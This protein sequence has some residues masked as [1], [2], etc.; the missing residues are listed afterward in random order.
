VSIFSKKNAMIG[1]VV[2]EAAKLAAGK[3]HEAAAVEPE[4]EKKPRRAGK[5][6]AAA[7][8]ALVAVGGVAA[9]R[10]RRGSGPDVQ[11]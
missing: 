8:G 11:E 2:L 5:A 9:L 7:T 6:L 3:R 4:P 1:W 10:R